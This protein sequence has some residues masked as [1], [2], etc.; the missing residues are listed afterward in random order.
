MRAGL[1]IIADRCMILR[2]LSFLYFTLNWL[3]LHKSWE[4]GTCLCI[5]EL[6][7]AGSTLLMGG[8]EKD[9][10]HQA[11]S[12]HGTGCTSLKDIFM[13]SNKKA[14]KPCRVTLEVVP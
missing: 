13:G 8:K 9:G 3:M 2:A 7:A 1:L 6:D 4:R 5:A 10:C 12:A 11:F 14:R